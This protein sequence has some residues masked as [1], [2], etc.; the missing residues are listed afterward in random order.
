MYLRAW[1]LCVKLVLNVVF[2]RP[3]KYSVLGNY[4]NKTFLIN[5][6]IVFYLLNDREYFIL[7]N[8]GFFKNYSFISTLVRQGCFYFLLRIRKSNVCVIWRYLL[9]FNENAVLWIVFNRE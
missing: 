7:L 5:I 9:I 3:N 8:R 2:M 1:S 4:L 6:G